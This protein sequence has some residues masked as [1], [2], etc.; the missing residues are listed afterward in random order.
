MRKPLKLLSRR[1]VKALVP[2]VVLNI[3]SRLRLKNEDRPFSSVPPKEIFAKVYAQGLWGGS[4]IKADF[5]SGCGSH[6]PSVV[7]PYVKSIRT[8]LGKLSTPPV[9]VDLGCGDFYVGNQICDLAKEYVACDI[10]EDL[11]QRNSNRF[12]KSNLRFVCLDAIDDRLPEGDIVFIRQVL[13]HLS[14]EQIAKIVAKITNY[15][16]AVITEHLPRSMN[17]K[18]NADKPAGPGIRLGIG[19]GVVLTEAPFSLVAMASTVLCE[20]EGYGGV[21]RTSLYQLRAAGD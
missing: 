13:Q 1:I 5:Y 7:D 21:I 15:T 11:I 12:R 6:D 4:D 19:S 3:R 10:V 2:R 17:F 8:F 9:I 18:A 14:N 20:I 16:F